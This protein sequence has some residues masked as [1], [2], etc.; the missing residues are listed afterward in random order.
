MTLHRTAAALA[1]TLLAVATVVVLRGGG[2]EPAAGVPGRPSALPGAAPGHRN[3]F[4]AGAALSDRGRSLIATARAR[5]IAVRARLTGRPHT[6]SARRFN[7]HPLPLVFLVKRRRGAWLQVH[8]P[9]RPNLGTGW[10]RA[11]DVRLAQTTYRL[12]VRLRS[13][14]LVLWRGRHAVIRTRIGTGRAVSPTPTGRY[15]VT[16]LIR[17]TDPRG[18]FGPYALGLSAHSRV[19]TRFEGGDG[20][21]GVHG[22]NAPSGLG[23][24]VSHGCIRVANA[25]ITRIAR[26][27]PLGTP[28]EITRA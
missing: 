19:Y 5:R 24:D 14:R 2:G 17:P 8:L 9:T 6:L 28:V 20:Q 26:R 27:V 16:D 22:T 7:G 13:H 1:V 23:Q 4:A 3:Q 11:R 18:F 12:Q 10:V 15:Y 25:V 21:I